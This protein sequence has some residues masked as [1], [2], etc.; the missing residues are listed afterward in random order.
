MS[1]ARSLATNTVVQAAGKVVST[2]LGVIIVGIM[3]RLLG[4]EGFGMYST[5]NAYMQVFAILLDLGLN[6]L[7]VQM[8]GEHAGDKT[9]EDKTVSAFFTLRL[10]TALVLLSLAPVIGLFLP[11]SPELKIALF[12][13]WGSFFFTAL[14]QVVI[15]V[16]QRHLK[17][18]VVAIAEVTGR[19]VLLVGVL[20]G[21]L[22][23]WGLIPIVLFVSLG[24]FANFA[25]N[26]LVAMRFANIRWNVDIP[27]WKNALKRAWPIG[28]SI[29][30]SLIYYK[31]DTLILGFVRTQSEVGIYGAA[32]RVLDILVTFP[33]MYAGVLLPVIAKAWANGQKERFSH[34]IQRS[35]DAFCLVVFP[36]VI[37]AQ[38]VATKG[39]LL[40]AGDKFIQSG[41]VLRILVIAVGVIYISTIF[42]HAIVA[43]DK[44]RSMLPV[45][46]TTAILALAGYIFLIPIYGMWAAAWLTVASEIAVMLGNIIITLRAVQ[47]KLKWNIARNTLLSAIAMFAI[48]LPFAKISLFLTIAVAAVAYTILTFA[49]KTVTREML[50][51]LLSSSR[52]APEGEEL[53]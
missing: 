18:H 53:L 48:A 27:F 43:L 10:L 23:H 16:H 30:F 9:Y 21:T 44:Q 50:T 40:V 26:A 35:F 8:L 31:A 2:V 41:N 15:G 11:Y 22:M 32:Y 4:Q 5:T 13:I 19:T 46:I 34:L 38:L 24:G 20:I 12:A 47:M 51:D 37:G 25:I 33:F 42:S 29:L 6:V 52:G 39:M 17:M 7:L 45:Y 36:I 28:V 1:V 14:N 3:T 49:T